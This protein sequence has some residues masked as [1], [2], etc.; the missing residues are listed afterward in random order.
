MS[1]RFHPFFLVLLLLAAFGFV[2]QLVR[3]PINTL[4]IL[5]L[6]A[7]VLFGVNR[8]LKTG[9]LMPTTRTTKRP[10]DRHAA[11][12]AKRHSHGIKKPYPFQVIDGRKGKTKEKPN[13]ED[14]HIQ[15]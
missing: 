6:S 9:R 8:Y 14:R 11:K 10:P 1:T 12:S 7:L 5:A 13:E 2:M 15:H 3:D 4:L